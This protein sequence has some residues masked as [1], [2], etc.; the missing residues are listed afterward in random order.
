MPPPVFH[1]RRLCASRNLCW[2]L[3]RGTYGDMHLQGWSADMSRRWL[4]DIPKEAP[5]ARG[6]HMTAIVD[7]NHDGIDEVMWG[8]R[9]V[10]LDGGRELF[11]LDEDTYR[12]H[13]DIVQPVYDWKNNAWRLYTVREGDTKVAPRVLLLQCPRRAHLGASKGRGTST[14][15]GWPEWGRLRLCGHGGAPVGEK[16]RAW[17]LPATRRST[18]TTWSR[19][20]SIRKRSLCWAAIRWISTATVIMSLPAGAS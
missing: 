4:L 7:W 19:G 16:T 3:L 1:F 20:G 13:S 12:G 8:E 10:E 15:A 6:S 9:C 18:T 17:A 5:E 14:A 11:C 2:S